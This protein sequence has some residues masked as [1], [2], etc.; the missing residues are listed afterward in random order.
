MKSINLIL[1]LIIAICCKAQMID[2]SKLTQ[3]F[4]STDIRNIHEFDSIRNQKL[5]RY[6]VESEINNQSK[7]VDPD[8]FSFIVSG[9]FHGASNSA[10]GMPAASLMANIDTLN[11]MNAAFIMCLGDLFLNV[12]RDHN[13]YEKYLFPKLKIPLL[14]AVGNHDVDN[15]FYR[16]HYGKTFHSFEI[17]SSRFIVLDS[18]MDNGD[19]GNSQLEFL[20]LNLKT[21][22]RIKNIF[23][24]MHRTLWVDMDEDLMKLFPDNT[25]SATSTNFKDE[26]FPMIAKASE[27][28]RV[29]L[30]SGSLGNAPAS[31]FYHPYNKKITFI[32]TAIRDLPRDAVLLVDS[33]QGKI[34]FRTFSLNSNVALPFENY[35]MDWWKNHRPEE[36]SFNWRLAPLYVWQMVT[37]R[38]FWY[39]FFLIFIP[40]LFY[41]LFKFF[42]RKIRA[43]KI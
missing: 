31:F 35:T 14:N 30:F 16:A 43:K 13:N 1:F 36:P 2:K 23:I 40:L 18:E 29:Y 6:K 8:Y 27:N 28:A 37:H 33:K 25:Q 22:N 7:L 3:G 24:F 17:G 11:G 15:E 32:A 39:G 4:N 41:Y 26:V 21:E 10:S 42:K 19:I 34:S 38:Y 20:K 5:V 12:D 9:H